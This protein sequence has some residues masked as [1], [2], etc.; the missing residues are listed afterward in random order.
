MAEVYA[1][2][3][4][5]GAL[6]VSKGV[7]IVECP[8]CGY[9]NNVT[10]LQDDLKAFKQEVQSW[11][12]DLGVAG[13]AGIDAGLRRLYFNNEIY[14]D[15]M[16]QLANIVSNTDDILDYP[17]V[18]L[19]LYRKFPDLG[20]RRKWS[21]D[22]GK[23]MKEYARRLSSPDLLAFAPDPASQKK[24]LDLRLQATM[25][26]TL[27][28]VVNMSSTPSPENLL[29]SANSLDALAN[30]V[31]EMISV[32]STDPALAPYVNYYSILKERFVIAAETYRKIRDAVLEREDIDEAW[33][34]E[35]V[36]A[37][38]ELRARVRAIKG[39]SVV[40]QVPLDYGLGNDI[41]AIKSWDGLVGTY[42]E[43]TN[44]PLADFI[45]SL[46]K[47]TDA[48]FFYRA[49]SRPGIDQSWFFDNVDSHK[50][51][52]FVDG[53]RKAVKGRDVKIIDPQRKAKSAKFLYPMYLLHVEAILRSGSLWWKKGVTEDFHVLVDGAFHMFDGFYQGDYPLLMT[54][55]GKKLVGKPLERKLDLVAKMSSGPA[56]SGPLVLPPAVSPQDAV[57]LFI[58]AHNFR[59]EAE[60]ARSEGR[61]IEVPSSYKKRGFDPGR[62]KAVNPRAVGLYYIPLIMERDR[63]ALAAEDFGLETYLPHRA[64]LASLFSEFKR[65]IA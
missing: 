52:W 11:L 4:C 48:T 40:E 3:N 46:E 30:D 33:T 42:I 24:I 64:R 15:L 54:P 62:V 16:T 14:P 51:A 39:I 23:P 57:N 28:D 56:P 58:N 5:G 49:A 6:R 45:S 1:C 37:L 34:E 27:M 25:I 19:G 22:I 31:D 36:K 8:Y 43:I 63:L 26:P 13:Q 55:I 44:R 32:I 18:Y 65:Q 10:Q 20:L 50:F 9:S 21:A 60:F 53:L 61:T 7:S 12:M 2:G 17:I 35:R 38:Q 47:F 29:R 41:S 59:E